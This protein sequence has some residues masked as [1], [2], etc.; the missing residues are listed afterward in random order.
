MEIIPH[1]CTM[2]ALKRL[3]PNLFTA[4]N[5]VGGILAIIFTLTGKIHLAPYCIFVS[6][7]FDFLDGFMARLLKVPSELG[8]QLDS[9]ADM[10]TF[11]VAPGIIVFVLLNETYPAIE[12]GSIRND[13]LFQFNLLNN[14]SMQNQLLENVN[15]NYSLIPFLALLIPVFALFRLAKFNL[16]TRQ[17]DSFIGLP[18]PAMTL[19]FAV[20]PIL[21]IQAYNDLA[22]GDFLFVSWQITFAKLILSPAFLIGATVIMSVLMVVEL[23]L[24]ALK[25]KSFKWKGN[26]LRF[27]FLGIAVILFATLFFWA[28]PLI[29]ILYLLLS[30]INN[31]FVKAKTNEI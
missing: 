13:A 6:A 10:V 8:K 26:E 5:L 29:I 23:P 2:Q 7:L 24:F 18:T 20:F 16:D 28:I 1:F 30:I 31:Q 3:V 17:S 14:E 12:F 19:F 4:G 9:L 15:Q 25:F 27:S 21:I 22:L 11:G